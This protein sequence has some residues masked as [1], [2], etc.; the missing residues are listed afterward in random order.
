MS[1][2]ILSTL[3]KMYGWLQIFR[4][5]IRSLLYMI[6][7]ANMGHRLAGDNSS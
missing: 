5:C 3:L 2:S 4:S 6:Q 1:S 7:D